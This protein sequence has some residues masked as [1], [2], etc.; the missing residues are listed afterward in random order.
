QR[1]WE[2]KIDSML[3]PDLADSGW[4]TDYY[5]GARIFFPDTP[6]FETNLTEISAY[7]QYTLSKY[8]MSLS[9]ISYQYNAEKISIGKENLREHYSK[10]SWHMSSCIIDTTDY[11]CKA[12][13]IA[14]DTLDHIFHQL[15]VCNGYYLFN[16]SA[17][18]NENEG[19]TEG[20]KQIAN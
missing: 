6:S 18:Y 19:D 4:V 16:V 12:T 20:Y 10:C 17:S 7:R 2:F 5:S 9:L 13:V 11:Q 8:Y 15:W 1:Y 14:K 3:S